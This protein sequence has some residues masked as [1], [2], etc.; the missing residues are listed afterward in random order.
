MKRAKQIIVLLTVFCML[1][2]IVTLYASADLERKAGEH[3]IVIGNV[4]EEA[5]KVVLNFEGGKSLS[6][7]KEEGTDA[8]WYPWATRWS[9]PDYWVC[10]D[11]EDIYER[12][13]I[14]SITVSWDDGTSKTIDPDGYITEKSLIVSMFIFV[15]IREEAKP[16]P[17]PTPVP[18][19][20]TPVPPTPTPTPTPTPVPVTPTPVPP[21][22]TPVPP[23]P[24]P[25][26]PTPTPDPITPKTG[27]SLNSLSVV[28]MVLG[29]AGLCSL[30]AITAKEKSRG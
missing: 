13:N 2:S 8:W 12:F 3:K 16:K 29:V 5:T 26:P 10:I 1:A 21:T 9:N 6:C 24:T 22:P 7:T 30:A 19:T 4:N 15:A 14:L 23:T 18:P 27:G 17:T 11:S 25:V 20:P 28:F